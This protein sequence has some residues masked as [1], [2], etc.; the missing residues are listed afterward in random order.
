MMIHVFDKL[1][2]FHGLKYLLRCHQLDFLSNI[3]QLIYNLLVIFGIAKFS[4]W[5]ISTEKISDG[6]IILV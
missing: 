2:Q 5:L 3:F 6:Q 4:K 1:E